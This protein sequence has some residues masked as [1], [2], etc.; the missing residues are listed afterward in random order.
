MYM[1]AYLICSQS[2][3]KIINIMTKNL[4]FIKNLIINFN[5]VSNQVQVASN[6]YCTY[7][8]A[9]CLTDLHARYSRWVEIGNSC[10]CGSLISENSRERLG[11]SF[12]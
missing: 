1:Y 4:W 11:F 6:M 5:I 3:T 7:T 9:V 2:L 8:I 10:L 12:Y